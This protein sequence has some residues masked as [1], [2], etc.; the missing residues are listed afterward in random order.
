MKGEKVIPS[1]AIR[2]QMFATLMNI[3]ATISV[4]NQN[5][6]V[7]GGYDIFCCLYNCLDDVVIVIVKRNIERIF[8]RLFT[9]VGAAGF[10]IE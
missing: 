5:E 8:F 9:S 7:C 4:R 10:C 6:Q 1:M 2:Q 3:V